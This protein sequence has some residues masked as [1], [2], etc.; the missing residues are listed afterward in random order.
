V[1]FDVYHQTE[2]VPDPENRVLLSDERDELGLR[3]VR[4]QWRWSERDRLGIMAAQ[5]IYA[6]AFK[7]SGIG[8]FLISQVDGEPELLIASTNHHIGT[9]RMHPDPRQGVVD[10]ECRVHGVANLFVASCSVFPTSG[11]A[12][13]TLTIVAL[14]LRLA[15]HLKTKFDSAPVVLSLA[16]QRSYAHV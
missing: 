16:A 9:T 2:Q 11:Y 10:S 5:R 4:L 6:Q 14:A 7:Q 12:N 1:L 8:N 15:D 3:K 13:P